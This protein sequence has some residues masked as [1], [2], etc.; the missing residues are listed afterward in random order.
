MYI[1]EGANGGS[2]THEQLFPDNLKACCKGRPWVSPPEPP[3]GRVTSCIFRSMCIQ[4]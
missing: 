4:S 2:L 3:Q 1:A